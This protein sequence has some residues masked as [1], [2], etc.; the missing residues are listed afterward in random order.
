MSGDG[1]GVL[2]RMTSL[3]KYCTEKHWD[4]LLA[5]IH[6]NIIQTGPL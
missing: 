3:I 1:I 5:D 2:K 6:N 4:L